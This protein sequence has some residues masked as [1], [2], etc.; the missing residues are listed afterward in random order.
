VRNGQFAEHWGV[1]DTMTMM[2]QLGA[3]PAP[4]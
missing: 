4:A 3:V 1:F 2:Q